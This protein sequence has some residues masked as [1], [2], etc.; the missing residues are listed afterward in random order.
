MRLSHLFR[1]V[2]GEFLM[3]AITRNRILATIMIA[4][5]IL[6]ALLNYIA[7]LRVNEVALRTVSFNFPADVTTT[8]HLKQGESVVLG[9]YQQLYP[10]WMLEFFLDFYWAYTFTALMVIGVLRLMRRL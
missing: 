4:G 9:S 6:L 2:N 10:A 3:K 8:V 5:V 7:Q 1:A